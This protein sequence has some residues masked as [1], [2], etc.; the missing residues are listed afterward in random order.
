MLLVNTLAFLVVQEF[1][2]AEWEMFEQL[3]F[4]FN[5]LD[6]FKKIILVSSMSFMTYKT[7]N[8]LA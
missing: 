5:I 4:E 2:K 8:A 3:L 7:D 6:L 1:K